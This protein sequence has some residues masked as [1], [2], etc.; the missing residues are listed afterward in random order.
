[1]SLTF[2]GERFLTEC[3]GEMV[4]EHWHRYLLAREYAS[5]KRVLDVASGEGYGAHLLAGVAES[6]VGVDL[7]EDAVKHASAKYAK[8][9]LQYIAASCTQIPLPD[10]SFDFIVS[11]ETIE[12]ID[13]A[14]QTAFL[15]EVNRL[16]KPD[17][18]FLISSPNRPEYSEKSGY[19]NEYH[20]KELDKE[21]LRSE[22]QQHWPYQ[23]WFGQRLSFYSI[24]WPIDRSASFNWASSVEGDRRFPEPVY[25]LVFCSKDENALRRIDAPLTFVSD[26]ENS[27]YEAWTRTYRDNVAINTEN[28][29]LR[30]LLD[31]RDASLIES[32]ASMPEPWLVRAARRLV[33]Q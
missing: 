2:T 31:E 29:R 14:A 11:F 18:L 28:Q 25:F 26:N 32:R 1:M 30:K 7:S 15:R 23:E 6:V 13:G 22:L 16:L 24:T 4:Y 27:V 5:G 19:M 10:A 17:G 33:G 3:Q 21:E 12:H 9:N 20:V 8:S